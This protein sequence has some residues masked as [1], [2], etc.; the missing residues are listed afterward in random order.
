MNDINGH[1]KKMV[2]PIII[3]I[4]FLIYILAYGIL[5]AW[6]GAWHPVF[7]LLALPLAALAVGMIKTL[8]SRINEIKE[9]EEDDLDNY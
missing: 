5:I 4:V 1:R 7:V 2:A 9:G 8:I 6:A 3:T